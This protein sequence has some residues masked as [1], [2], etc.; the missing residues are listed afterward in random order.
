MPQS[1][2]VFPFPLRLFPVMPDAISE[3]V[4]KPPVKISQFDL[5]ACHAESIDPASLNLAQFLDTFVET[6]RGGFA[7]DSF[8]FVLYTAPA[9]F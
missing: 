2:Q 7:G 8:K 6:H 1:N 9:L 5:H 4:P 3:T